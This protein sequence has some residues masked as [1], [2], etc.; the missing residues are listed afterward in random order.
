M[1]FLAYVTTW[2]TMLQPGLL[3]APSKFSQFGKAVGPVIANTCRTRGGVRYFPGR[4]GG[5][6]KISPLEFY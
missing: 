6:L 2:I 5:N 4:G 1:D 3:W